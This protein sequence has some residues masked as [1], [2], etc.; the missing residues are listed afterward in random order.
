[1]RIKIGNVWFQVKHD[2]PIMLEL[3]ERDKTNILNMHP[4]ATKYAIFDDD[5]KMTSEEKLEWME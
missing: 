5:D 3:S 1:M 2:Q 4:E